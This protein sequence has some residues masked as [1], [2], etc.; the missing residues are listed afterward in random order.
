[1]KRVN[2]DLL[3]LLRTEFLSPT[4]FEQEVAGLNR[5]LHYAFH[6][7]RFSIAHELVANTRITRRKKKILQARRQPELKP[8]YF[9]INLN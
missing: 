7:E 1:M 6:D 8:F 2:K 3:V 9:L 4:E 5:L